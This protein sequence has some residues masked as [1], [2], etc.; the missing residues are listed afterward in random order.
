[1]KK[2]NV[3]NNIIIPIFIIVV[4]SLAPIL[5]QNLTYIANQLP[6]R[7]LVFI[8]ACLIAYNFYTQFTCLFKVTEFYGQK[9]AYLMIFS[10]ILIPLAVLVPY[11][12]KDILWSMIHVWISFGGSILFM[13]LL[14]V[15]LWH[16]AKTHIEMYQQI[17][18]VYLFLITGCFTLFVWLGSVSS[19][20]EI[21]FICSLNA[22]IYQLNRLFKL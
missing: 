14:N 17:L 2:W 6:Y 20:V 18:P 15:F 12:K 10:L 1:M 13:I 9:A 5:H 19:L 21:F 4:C 16:L 3:L 11:N 22:L 7:F 8:L